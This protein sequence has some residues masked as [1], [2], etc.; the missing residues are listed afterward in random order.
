MDLTGI[1]SLVFQRYKC[2]THDESINA[3]S[4]ETI[5][6]M[7]QLVPSV[8]LV[9]GA[10]L[11]YTIKLACFVFNLMPLVGFNFARVK[12]I[13]VLQWITNGG[14]SDRTISLSTYSLKNIYVAYWNLIKPQFEK[15]QINLNTMTGTVLR[16]DHTYKIVKN[17]SARN[18]TES[19]RVRI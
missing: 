8:S 13:L 7:D 6:E 12:K 15:A 16:G 14:M 18:N 19:K 4:P 17:I 2:Q 10:R 1:H 11:V 3:M 5:E 9:I